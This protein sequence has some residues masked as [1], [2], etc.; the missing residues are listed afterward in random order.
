MMCVVFFLYLAMPILFHFDDCLF[1]SCLVGLCRWGLQS[2]REPAR[3]PKYP[4]E[5]MWKFPISPAT[6]ILYYNLARI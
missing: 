3:A 6:I 1:K 5:R 2:G 4:K